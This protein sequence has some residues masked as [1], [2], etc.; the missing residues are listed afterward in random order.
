[1][2]DVVD[3]LN[4]ELASLEAE[5]RDDPRYRKIERIRAL[6]SEY[7]SGTDENANI[8]RNP[9]HWANIRKP[10]TEQPNSKGVRVRETIRSI[11]LEK[12]A[13][14]RTDLL[15]ALLAKGIMGNEKAPMA[16]LAAYLSD[17]KEF[18]S[19]GGGQWA[20]AH[21]DDIEASTGETMEA[22]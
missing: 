11:L 18:T 3:M 12:G 4:Q 17:F 14:H 2:S 9:V 1:M 20:L 8:R 5:L 6:L 16:S 19:V 13:V 7:S 15:N 22:S 10:R 21:P